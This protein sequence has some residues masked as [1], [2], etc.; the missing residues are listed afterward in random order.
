MAIKAICDGCKKEFELR[1]GNTGGVNV[2]VDYCNGEVRTYQL[3][4]DCCK[5]AQRGIE[6]IAQAK[7]DAEALVADAKKVAGK[8]P[9]NRMAEI[10]EKKNVYDLDRITMYLLECCGYTLVFPYR[11]AG[12]NSPWQVRCIGYDAPSSAFPSRPQA[13][14][15]FAVCN[16]LQFYAVPGSSGCMPRVADRTL[17]GCESDMARS[18]IMKD[19]NGDSMIVRLV[20]TKAL[21]ERRKKDE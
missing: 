16:D 13:V 19:N 12:R 9:L 14:D 18:F 4:T 11:K 1:Y 15:T 20:D 3:C 5:N 17:W 2:T 21:K 6:D 7:R 10:L 8:V